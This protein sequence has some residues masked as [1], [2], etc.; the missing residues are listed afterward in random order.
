MDGQRFDQVTRVFAAGASRRHALGAMLGV[1][2][3]AL[4]LSDADARGVCRVGG[5]I[6]RVNRD[7][8]S[9]ACVQGSSRRRHCAEC[10]TGADC[11]S[12][13]SECQSATCTAGICGVAADPEKE[14][15]A[16][17]PTDPC[18]VTGYCYSGVCTAT[19][20]VPCP[21]CS[22]CVGGVCTPLP[23]NGSCGTGLN[24]CGGDCI[25]LGSDPTH[26]GNC[27]NAC[28]TPSECL[29]AVCAD[30]VCGAAPNPDKESDACTPDDPCLLSGYCHTGVCESSGPKCGVCQTCAA[31]ICQDAGN[32]TNCPAGVCQG[33]VCS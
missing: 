32:G 1:A 27:P 31:G 28:P 13:P 7:C 25:D 26:C 5:Q 22:P 6:C 20:F 4:G 8:C 24:C 9:T 21:A 33:G 19:S 29:M 12:A 17:T 15:D 11:P 2:L 23:E 3:S 10:V 30:R 18:S 16:C 14:S